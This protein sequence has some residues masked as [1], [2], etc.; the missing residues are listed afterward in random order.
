MDSVGM[1]NFCEEM[2]HTAVERVTGQT[3]VPFGDYDI[4]FARTFER[5][6]MKEAIIKYWPQQFREL[7]DERLDES[8]LND[9]TRVRQ[10]ILFLEE[11]KQMPPLSPPP[12]IGGYSSAAE[13]ALNF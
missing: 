10:L 2:L 7:G 1:M 13:Q 11:Q 6:T 9:P 12:A 8:W 5:L 3:R 4:D